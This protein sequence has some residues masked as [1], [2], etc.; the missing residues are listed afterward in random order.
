MKILQ[1]TNNMH[2]GG[3]EKL[4]L[5]TIPIHN[6]IGTSMDLAVLCDNN[7][8]FLEMLKNYKCCE[9]FSLGSKSV[10]NP[11][12][13][14]KIIP[15]FKKYDIIHVHLFPCLYWVAIAKIISFSNCKLIFTEHSTNNRRRKFPIFK[16]LDRLIYSN[17]SQIIAIT[18]EVKTELERH[19]SITYNSNIVVINN[20]INIE[21]YRKSN[22]YD[23]KIFFNTE[24]VIILIQVSR[25]NEPKDQPTVIKAMNLLPKNIKLLLVGDGELKSNCEK[26]VF[27]LALEERVL[28]LGYRTDVP[29]L[30]NT[31]DIIIQSS[32]WEGF[33]LA[34][35]EGMAIGKPVIV[36]DVPG[37]SD[38]VHGAGL[39]FSK[40]DYVSLANQILLLLNIDLYSEISNKVKIRANEYSIHKTIESQLIL[41]NS[42]L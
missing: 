40:G 7:P 12:L 26:L 22:R 15:F 13:V 38:L 23:K 6:A 29:E 41:Y 10:Y 5:E 2:S 39:L 20:G 25:F 31:S 21:K 34:A 18:K 4:L 1:F 37:L 33:G 24:D 30:M 11:L 14:F 9:I 42:I 28:F 32:N 19:L 27:N 16:L 8:P 35:L 36:S 3:A 17:Y